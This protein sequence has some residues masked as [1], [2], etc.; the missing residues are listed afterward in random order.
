MIKFKFGNFSFEID[1]I[2]LLFLTLVVIFLS[3][4]FGLR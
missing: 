2:G 1:E 3:I 4:V